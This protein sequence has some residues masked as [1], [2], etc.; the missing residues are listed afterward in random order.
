MPDTDAPDT[1]IIPETLAEL[2]EASAASVPEPIADVAATEAVDEGAVA[3]VPETIA[4]AAVAAAP[5]HDDMADVPADAML[6]ELDEERPPLKRRLADAFRDGV[7]SARSNRSRDRAAS[8][9]RSPLEPREPREKTDYTEMLDWA[10]TQGRSAA[11]AIRDTTAAAARQTTAVAFTVAGQIAARTPDATERLSQA[12]REGV[13]S[14]KRLS[15]AE[16]TGRVAQ[17]AGE[18]ASA[19]WQFVA[20]VFDLVRPGVERSASRGIRLA[21]RRITALY[22]E[23]GR[24]AVGAWSDGPVATE[25]LTA[26]LDEL[27][28]NEEEIQRL[29]AVIETAAAERAA[30]RQARA[31]EEKPAKST[32][33]RGARGGKRRKA[34]E[35]EG[36]VGAEP[37]AEAAAI[38]DTP[39]S[40]DAPTEAVST[41]GE[42]ASIEQPVA[43]AS[44][45]SGGDVVE[46]AEQTPALV[47]VESPVSEAIVDELPAAELVAVESDAVVVEVTEAV[48]EPAAGDAVAT[49]EADAETEPD[50]EADSAPD[51]ETGPAADASQPA[52]APRSKKKKKKKNR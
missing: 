16:G 15:G 34:A 45:A 5:V 7:D 26:L 36:A 27:R 9:P 4:E 25:K 3:A 41:E 10:L 8:S 37:A 18:G 22:G 14:V 30:A 46:T 33:E 50:D 20:D 35:G 13:S 44:D 48:V 52:D 47:D 11:G 21:N 32:A 2:D 49:D 51:D 6:S 43:P 12:L 17:A 24:E 42:P 1:P 31:V 38:T 40:S 28:K 19:A 29:T 23:I 39:P